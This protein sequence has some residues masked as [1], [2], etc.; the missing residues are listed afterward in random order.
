MTGLKLPRLENGRVRL[1]AFAASDIAVV[2]AASFD[3]HIPLIT[4]VPT[5]DSAA[6]ALAFIAQQHDR[7]TTLAGYSFAIADAHTDEA[8]GQ[9]GLWL[10]N[11]D[12][13]RADIGYWIEAGHRQAGYA[14]AALGLLTEWAFT[15]TEVARLELSVEPWN[16]PSWRLAERL[17]FRR[18][19][20]MRQWQRVGKER[21]DMYF[22]ALLRSDVEHV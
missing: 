20:L 11:I 16:E 12:N 22:Y 17:G 5:N 3:P 6:D 1:R 4:T 18:E 19:G 13:G 14:T 15:I 9:I 2:Q 10:R 7:L 8:V 21:K